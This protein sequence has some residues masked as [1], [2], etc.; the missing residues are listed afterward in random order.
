MTM[1]TII[2][3]AMVWMGWLLFAGTFLGL[4]SLLLGNLT[5][6]VGK[7]RFT[8]AFWC[9]FALLIFV[10]QITNLFSG[11]GP[12]TSAS[13][14]AVGLCGLFI[15]RSR[16]A[17]VDFL[18][19]WKPIL[20]LVCLVWLSNRALHA[21][22]YDDSGIYHFSSIRWANQMPLVPGLGNLHGRLAFNQSYFLFVAFL[23]NFPMAGFGHNLANSL[24]L[25]AGMLTVFEMS[26]ASE[27]DNVFG[28]LI[29]LLLPITLFF[30]ATC[31]RSNAP[32]I[33]SPSPDAAVFTVE[34][35]LTALLLDFLR[36]PEIAKIDHSTT[37]AAIVCLASVSVSLKLSALAFVGATLVSAIALAVRQ[38]GWFSTL[39]TTVLSGF[40]VLFGG[41]W[42]I[43]SVLASGYL[44]YPLT[45][46]GL[47]VDWK[48]PEH[49]VRDELNGIRGYARLPS[50]HWSE[51]TGSWG[52]FPQ[53]LVRMADR[54]DIIA[55]LGLISVCLICWRF[56]DGRSLRQI[57]SS[58]K[59]LS[60]LLGIGLISLAFWFWNAPDARFL[61]VAL[62]I[63]LLAIVGIALDSIT[64]ER[65]A[66]MSRVVFFLFWLSV[67]L[68]FV[69]NGLALTISTEGK[70]AQPIP[71]PVLTTRITRSG[72]VV[73]TPLPG[74]YCWDGA[75]P[76][77]PYFR[78]QLKLR[79][80]SLA[81][82]FFID[83]SIEQAPDF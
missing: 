69:R 70:L 7:W 81:K 53:W 6:A 46:S 33:S 31:H 13:L 76:S 11:I 45:A 41:I 35:V 37:M 42:I 52:W 49:L 55:P 16:F 32:V 82:G 63:M 26:A 3:M 21:P 56:F 67:V 2:G 34:I 20:L 39:K 5:D 66:A 36:C 9:G 59:P 51:A 8:T 60:C 4:G 17:L 74:S 44:V 38:R 43:R 75:L 40:A 61:G 64:P 78:S 57:P 79:G 68:C 50:N 22:I 10:L 48:I 12:R 27:P 28:T 65:R 72:L 71:T 25:S 19:L 18:P 83:E 23:N 1:L 30:V 73:H 29:R 80:S 14:I 47:P 54:P 15:H 58:A 24:L 77:T 62:W